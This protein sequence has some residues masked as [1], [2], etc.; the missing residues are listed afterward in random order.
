MKPLYGNL[1]QYICVFCGGRVVHTGR[2][3]SFYCEAEGVFFSDTRLIR[4][5]D[6]TKTA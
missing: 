3:P 6:H 4:R 1:G 5:R 2:E